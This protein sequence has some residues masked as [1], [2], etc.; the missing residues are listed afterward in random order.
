MKPLDDILAAARRSPKRIALS[1]G[2]D[3]R[4]A[5]AAARALREGIAHPIL[6]GKRS[7]VEDRLSATGAGP[8]DF[9]I[10]APAAAPKAQDYADTYHVLRKHK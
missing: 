10:I 9:E 6:V 7:T 2:E 3:P 5:E 8:A 1:E 4:I